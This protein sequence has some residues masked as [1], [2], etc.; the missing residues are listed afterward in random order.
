VGFD[1]QV[2]EALPREPHDVPLDAVVTELRTLL[3]PRGE[4]P[5]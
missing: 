4:G 3:F 2:V 5:A 1:L